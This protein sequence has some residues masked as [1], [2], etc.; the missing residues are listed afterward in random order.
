[1]TVIQTK[2][3]KHAVSM[4]DAINAKYVIVM[5][6]GETVTRGDLK[7]D[8][9]PKRVLKYPRDELKKY[10]KSRMDAMAIGDVL[11]VKLPTKEMAIDVRGAAS[12]YGSSKWGNKSYI[13]AVEGTSVELLRIN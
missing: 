12:A 5:P 8:T 3:L 10:Y 13:S 11:D 2:A 1:M 6:D 4:L 7:V 9:S